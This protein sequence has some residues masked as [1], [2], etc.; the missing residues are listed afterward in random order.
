MR[1]SQARAPH[2]IHGCWVD[3]AFDDIEGFEADILDGIQRSGTI[4]IHPNGWGRHDAVGVNTDNMHY[5][6]DYSS[7]Q[8]VCVKQPR[9][10]SRE[11]EQ[12]KET[13]GQKD[14]RE[15]LAR[16]ASRK[17]DE[18]SYIAERDALMAKIE[19][20]PHTYGSIAFYTALGLMQFGKA[21]AVRRGI[22]EDEWIWKRSRFLAGFK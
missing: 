4:D 18:Q 15:A 13:K 17:A 21:D 10:V 3:P 2:R 6:A 11:T 12:P 22:T 5:L 14:I 20:F 1:A 7:L 16:T 8:D 9:I 19:A